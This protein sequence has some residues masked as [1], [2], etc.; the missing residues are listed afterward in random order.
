M[1][2]THLSNILKLPN[3]NLLSSEISFK[4]RVYTR[5]ECFEMLNEMIDKGKEKKTS[6]IFDYF[7]LN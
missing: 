1:T 7:L 6:L 2:T 5:N 3:L 4:N